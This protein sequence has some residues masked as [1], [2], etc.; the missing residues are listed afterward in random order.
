MTYDKLQY[1]AKYSL[2]NFSEMVEY[3][4]PARKIRQALSMAALLA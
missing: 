1:L 3:I 4:N 2:R